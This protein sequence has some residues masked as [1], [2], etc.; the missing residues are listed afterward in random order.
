[1]IDIIIPA[2]NCSTTLARTLASIAA[3][4]KHR[5][6]VT[7]VDDCSTEDLIPIIK[8]FQELFSIRYI[9]TDHN[10]KYPGLVRQVGIDASY[11]PYIM[12][13]DSDDILDPRAVQICN[14]QM[15]NTE[16]DIIIGYFF[17]Q[18]RDEGYN[19]M[20]ESQTTWLHGNVYR[21]SFLKENNIRFDTG[22]NEDGA[23][24]TQCFLL[25]NKI[26]ISNIPIYYWMNSNTSIT[27]SNKEF[28]LR[29]CESLPK[30]LKLAYAN[31]IKVQDG[32][33]A[34]T[35]NNLGNHLAFFWDIANRCLEKDM[36]E[37]FKEFIQECKIFISDLSLSGIIEKSLIMAAFD[38]K[39]EEYNKTGSTKILLKEEF[40]KQIGL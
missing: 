11:E 23:F 27:R 26:A 24:N 30:T 13:L 33:T 29:T 31:V 39:F 40:L 38:T 25:S 34:K 18:M 6:I 28:V 7:I 5:A 22:Y 21:R 8:P 15:M 17:C 35:A 2:Y 19:V 10:L 32:I 36:Q 4:T 14:S 3:Q 12:F 9:K 20:D 1:M 16:A 37:K